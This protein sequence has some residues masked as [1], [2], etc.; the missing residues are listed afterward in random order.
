M[1]YQDTR[2]RYAE[3]GEAE[4]GAAAA[5]VGA[6]V[7]GTVGMFLGGPAGAIIGAGVGGGAG[8]LY[9]KATGKKAGSAEGKRAFLAANRKAIQKRKQ[10]ED[11]G[12]LMALKSSTGTTGRPVYSDDAVLV[13]NFNNVGSGV[14]HDRW[15][16]QKF[17]SPAVFPTT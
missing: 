5:S 9:G 13:Q 14:S 4:G 12:Q 11:K 7:G 8:W 3:A 2:R 1:G 16:S 10:A 17:G 6:K 15:K